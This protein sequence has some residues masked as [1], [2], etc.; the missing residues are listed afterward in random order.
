MA[1]STLTAWSM[2][3]CFACGACGRIGFGATTGESNNP[4]DPDAA[5]DGVVTPPGRIAYVAP[6]HA[7]DGGTAAS[8]HSFTEQARA[9]GHAIVIQVACAGAMRPQNVGLAA[10][11]WTF[12]R[13]GSITPSA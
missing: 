1:R 7:S 6:F 10:E 13:L 5:V 2:S 9:A 8:Q 11:G 3:A 12:R 4:V